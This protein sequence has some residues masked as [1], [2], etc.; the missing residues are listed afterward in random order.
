[1][2]KS[3]TKDRPQAKTE[4]RQVSAAQPDRMKT[5]YQVHTLATMLYREMAGPYAW[6][7]GAPTVTHGTQVYGTQTFAPWGASSWSHPTPWIR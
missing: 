6:T 7:G 4:T 1:M 3:A 2:T 5:A